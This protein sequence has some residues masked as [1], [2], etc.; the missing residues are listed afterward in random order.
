MANSEPREPAV[1]FSI[2]PDVPPVYGPTRARFLAT[3]RGATERGI[4]FLDLSETPALGPSWSLAEAGAGDRWTLITVFV[5]ELPSAPRPG[6]FPREVVGLAPAWGSGGPDERHRGA[7]G[8]RY[9][10]LGAAEAGAVGAARAGARWVAVPGSVLDAA[11]L[12]P[13]A[14]EI[15][16]AGARILLTNP[17]ADGRLDGRWL[18]EGLGADTRRTRPLELGELERSYGPVLALGFLTEGRRRTLPQAAVAFALA[19]GAV[20]S[21]RFRDVGQLDAFGRP[22][23]VVPLTPEELARAVRA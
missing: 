19:I 1:A 3:I 20:P 7:T 11:R 16:A 23:S 18:A 8:V 10:E 22:E 2:G 14:E 4:G 6:P 12:V 17:H 21:V 15:R 5:P 9:R 13:L